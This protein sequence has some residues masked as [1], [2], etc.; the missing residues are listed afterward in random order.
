MQSYLKLLI[1]SQ[2]IRDNLFKAQKALGDKTMIIPVLKANA[3]GHGIENIIRI[4]KDIDMIDIVA[5]GD[6][7]EAQICSRFISKDHV[8]ALF[9]NN[10]TFLRLLLEGYHV[11]L[12]STRQLEHIFNYIELLENVPTVNLHVMCN[13]GFQRDG[14]DIGDFW[15]LLNLLKR[16]SVKI[17]TLGVASHIA[18]NMRKNLM[19]V[20]NKHTEEYGKFMKATEHFHLRCNRT[21]YHIANTCAGFNYPELLEYSAVRIGDGIYGLNSG[22]DYDFP[23]NSAISCI[24]RVDNIKRYNPDQS[25]QY[26]QDFT[27]K[28]S[29]RIGISLIGYSDALFSMH[30]MNYREGKIHVVINDKICQVLSM[31]MMNHFIYFLP[32]DLD[33][34]IGDTVHIFGSL[35]PKSHT[36][37][38]WA[39]TMNKRVGE[40]LLPISPLVERVL[41]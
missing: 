10:D 12:H 34:R 27:L 22:K 6:A 3:Y 11:M 36:V 19:A 37:S 32:D 29:T 24:T 5:V 23:Y 20:K 13:T 38:S 18:A 15:R 41:F 21:V 1:D 26:N 7:D 16:S 39:N 2:I 17:N 8:L 28:N 4:L 9:S 33:V 25:L 40:F 35:S 30:T 31:P 14:L